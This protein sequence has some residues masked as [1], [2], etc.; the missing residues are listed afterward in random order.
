MQSKYLYICYACRAFYK[1]T[2]QNID[3]RNGSG[4]RK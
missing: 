2:N 3:I 1:L 4:T